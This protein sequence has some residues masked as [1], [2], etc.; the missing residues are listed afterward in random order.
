MKRNIFVINILLAVILAMFISCEMEQTGTLIINLPG[1]GTERTAVNDDLIDKLELSYNILIKGSSEILLNGVAAGTPVAREVPVGKY[2]INI[3]VLDAVGEE[4]G[5]D[6]QTKNVT[7]G[8]NQVTFN[9]K[10]ELPVFLTIK[11]IENS[12][13]D[14]KVYIFKEENN[15]TNIASFNSNIDSAIA[16]GDIRTE[17]KGS[18]R[19]FLIIDK[20]SDK[21]W[22]GTGNYHVILDGGSGVTSAYRY[23]KTK[24]VAKFS[25]GIGLLDDDK[26]D[27]EYLR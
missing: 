26:G 5:K 11:G 13:D 8:R 10:I 6:E 16:I 12:R 4:I 7:P 22:L 9:I 17:S 24:I 2:K 27:F 1:G 19:R 25:N 3:T 20:E 15:I 18:V 23:R 21:L 14:Y